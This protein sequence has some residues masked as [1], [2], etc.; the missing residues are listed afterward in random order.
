MEKKLLEWSKFMEA[1]VNDY[2][3]KHKEEAMEL[4]PELGTGFGTMLQQ[5]IFEPKN[6][7]QGIIE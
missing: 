7:V 3:D 2:Y 5:Y 4:V 1:G 6:L